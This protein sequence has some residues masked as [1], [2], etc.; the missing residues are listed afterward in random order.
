MEDVSEKRTWT[1]PKL[2]QLAIAETAVKGAGENESGQS[3]CGPAMGGGA[4][5]KCS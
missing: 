1:A 5:D 3:A 2:E 4:Q